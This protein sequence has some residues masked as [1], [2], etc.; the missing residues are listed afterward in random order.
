MKI[1]QKGEDDEYLMYLSE[2]KKGWF[3]VEKISGMEG[4]VAIKGSEAWVHG[5]VLGVGTINYGGETLELLDAP[6]SGKVVERIKEEATLK[7][8][9]MQGDWVKVEYKGV[10]GWIHRDSLCGSSLTNCS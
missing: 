4:D 7:L 1:V 9:D 3:K 10:S 8:K 5:S 6:K 2:A